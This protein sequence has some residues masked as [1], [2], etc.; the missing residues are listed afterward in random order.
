M[1][2]SFVWLSVAL[3]FLSAIAVTANSSALVAQAKARAEARA[4]HDDTMRKLWEDQT[5][6]TRLFIVSTF[7]DLPDADERSERLLQNQEA[8]GDVI[9][10]FYGD[11]A[12]EQLT[13]LLRQHILIM[14]EILQAAEDRDQ[15]A[16]EDAVR[17]WY[18]NA[19]EIAVFLH[20]VNPENWPLDEMTATLREHLALTLQV[21]RA[22]LSRDY[23]GSLSAYEEVRM[24]ALEMADMLSN[25]IIRQFPNLF[26]GG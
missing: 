14:A 21:A 26:R 13:E 22:E 20:T 10:P 7:S 24:Q 19:D 9:K 16:A 1:G 15:A 5:A 4:L 6:L 11:A 17:R 18:A 2:K 8:I 3:L 12:G 23:V 25:G